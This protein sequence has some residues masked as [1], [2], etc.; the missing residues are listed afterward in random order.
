MASSQQMQDIY[1][2]AGVYDVE[3]EED[4]ADDYDD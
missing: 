1:R 4:G 2:F 3:T